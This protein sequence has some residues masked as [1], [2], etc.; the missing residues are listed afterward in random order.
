MLKG[1]DGI[2]SFRPNRK[3][4]IKEKCYDCSGFCHKEVRN[5]EH[6]DCQIYDFRTGEDKQDPIARDKAIRA[7]CLWC[8]N[9]SRKEVRFVPQLRLPFLSIS[10]HQGIEEFRWVSGHRG[11]D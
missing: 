4:A 11:N 8:M 10:E 1:D 5:C 2:G 6:D 7:F 9:G 3:D